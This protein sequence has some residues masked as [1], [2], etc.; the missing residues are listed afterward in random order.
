MK[1]H[2]YQAREI[3]ASYG[4][5]LSKGKVAK[6][7]DEAVRAAEEMG[8]S[9][10]A[11]KA[12]VHAGGRGKGGGVKLARSLDQVAEFAGALIGS[13]LVTPQT[14]PEGAYVDCVLIQ[15]GLK[16]AHEYYI[17]Y[18]IDRVSQ[19]C[20]LLASS[21]GGMDIEKVAAQTPEKIVRVEIELEE[22][23]K[24]E[25]ALYVAAKLGVPAE[26]RQEAAL[27]L[28]KLWRVFS[29]MDCSLLEINPLIQTE[30][31]RILPLDVKINFDDNALFRH[32]ELEALSDPLQEDPTELAAHKAGLQ[33]IQLG[34]NIACLVNGAGLAMATM[35]TIRL[36]G[37]KPSNFL[38]IG[39]GASVE[40]VTAAF[41]IMNEQPEV[42]AIL[43]NIFGGI[44][45]CDTIAEGIVEACRVVSPKVPLVV[46]MRGTNEEKGREILK[47]SG[48]VIHS[49][50]TLDEAARLAV[51]FAQGDA[52]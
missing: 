31:G 50:H 15:E 30:D 6:N 14:G 33:Y 21:A 25:S 18:L 43:V 47:E 8:G 10:W 2:E 42:K 37:G 36:F 9:V 3:L 26:Q 32:P 16:I 5:P 4:V 40:R 23:L 1:I 11:V 45:K 7:A 27:V 19:K 22:G 24:E 41:K 51:R 12:Q 29:E 35:D 52:E 28:R 20:M 38:D 13:R 17:G 39:G 48:L 34:G 49:A 44:M 46:R